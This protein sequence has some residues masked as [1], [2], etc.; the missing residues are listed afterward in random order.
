[1]LLHLS[2]FF[3]AYRGYSLFSSSHLFLS[4]LKSNDLASYR[5]EREVSGT[6]DPTKA[7]RGPSS[8]TEVRVVHR[9]R[10]MA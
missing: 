4:V 1:M 8:S 3:C 5:L 10:D 7:N 6:I 9:D 2:L